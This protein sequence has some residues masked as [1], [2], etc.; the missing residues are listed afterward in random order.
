MLRIYPVEL[1]AELETGYGSRLPTGEYTPPD[2][3][4][5]D[6]WLS[7]VASASAVCTGL[8]TDLR[9]Q[10]LQH[11]ADSRFLMLQLHPRVSTLRLARNRSIWLVSSSKVRSCNSTLS[12]CDRVWAAARIL[13]AST[14]ACSTFCTL[15]LHFAHD[16]DTTSCFYNLFI[17]F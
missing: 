8:I 3:T 14:P 1:A 13:S 11:V 17:D 6:S 12:A 5:L 4:Q 15:H 10:S 7:W 2:A 16:G 9:W